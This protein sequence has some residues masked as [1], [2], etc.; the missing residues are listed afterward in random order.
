MQMTIEES[1][2][3]AGELQGAGVD[4]KGSR[5]FN[6][7]SGSGVRGL[8]RREAVG[9]Q[10]AF[11]GQYAGTGL[12]GQGL[13]GLGAL[14]QQV[15]Q[16]AIASGALGAEQVA[17]VGGRTG[18]QQVLGKG[19]AQMLQGSMG[20]AMMAAG[21]KGGQFSMQDVFGL[22]AMQTMQQAGSRATS[23]N[24]SALTSN[25]QRFMRE[26]MKDPTGAAVQ[27]MGQVTSAADMLTRATPGLGREDAI[28]HVLQGQGMNAPDADAFLQS[29]KVMPEAIRQ[30]NA[31]QLRGQNELILSQGMEN[32][33]ITGRISRY[34]S[35]AI[36]PISIYGGEQMASVQD[37]VVNMTGD[38]RDR[39]VGVKRVSLKL[40][41][42]SRENMKTVI[43][44]AGLGMSEDRRSVQQAKPSEAQKQS[45]RRNVSSRKNSAQREIARLKDER[46]PSERKKYAREIMKK[47]GGK[48]YEEGNAAVRKAYENAAMEFTN[49][50]ISGALTEGADKADADS[51]KRL[52]EDME[53][54]RRELSGGFAGELIGGVGG[55]GGGLAVGTI[56]A[57]LAGPMGIL[58]AA[59]GTAAPI[60]GGVFG[61]ELGQLSGLGAEE[62]AKLMRDPNVKTAVELLSKGDNVTPEEA[63]ARDKAMTEI[64]KM[65]PDVGAKI[66]GM[67][68]SKLKSFNATLEKVRGGSGESA[69]RSAMSAG[70]SAV[71]GALRTLDGR[72]SEAGILGAAGRD[73][74]AVFSSL[75]DM[76][77]SD[78]ERKKLLGQG[79][80]GQLLLRAADIA[81]ATTEG[82][83][84]KAVGA[85]RAEK[86]L[87]SGEKFSPE[88]VQQEALL[89]LQ[90]PYAIEGI[91]AGNTRGST[92]EQTAQQQATLTFLGTNIDV[93]LRLEKILKN[94]EQRP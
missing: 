92:Q 10:M 48:E 50:N 40:D 20:Q 54:G 80:E 59:I 81:S 66:K 78:E 36:A 55:Y 12:Q 73:S 52:Q 1:A 17:A 63:A 91:L 77:L 39:I 19:V 90:R 46:D 93:L 23:Q 58:G 94:I 75:R 37:K 71:A 86:I 15:G 76:N 22:D 30:R 4:I 82:E 13:L 34:G 85:K 84:K 2:G 16:T 49:E 74:T 5:A 53:A 9:G 45:A 61:V 47:L 33:S 31:E 69:V 51:E 83:L 70:S 27:L 3:L 8:T 32:I 11:A 41:D 65:N 28:R 89:A 7:L 25:P 24:L 6:A 60:A 88:L 38:L 57:I 67:S 56:G 87:E 79:P 21:M 72:E 43:S 18:A 42:I 44:K 14:S 68:K 35:R 64:N 62:N 29:F 26:A